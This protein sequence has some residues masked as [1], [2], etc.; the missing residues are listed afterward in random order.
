A[1][2]HASAPGSRECA[3]LRCARAEVRSGQR[4]QAPS[5]GGRSD[6]CPRTGPGRCAVRRHGHDLIR[7]RGCRSGW[8]QAQDRPAGRA[9]PPASRGAGPHRAKYQRETWGMLCRAFVLLLGTLGLAACG[10]KDT[11]APTAINQ[12]HGQAAG[13]TPTPGPAAAGPVAILLPLS[14]KMAEIGKPMLWGAQ[15]ALSIPGAPILDVKDTDGTPEGAARAAQQ[16]IEGGAR[17]ILGPLTSAETARVAPIAQRAA[18]PVL[19]FTNDQGQAQP[20]GW[21]LGITP[22]QQ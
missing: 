20:G 13:T 11:G 4:R 18:V 7:L 21:T 17:I 19:A 10:A 22:G 2:R 1:C 15:L 14:G 9:A 16:A 12:P 3:R 6:A 5:A 8:K